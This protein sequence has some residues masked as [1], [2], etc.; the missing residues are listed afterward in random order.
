MIPIFKM[1]LACPNCPAKFKLPDGVDPIGKTF[2]CSSCEHQWIFTS[3]EDQ[4]TPKPESLQNQNND[5]LEEPTESLGS[6][7]GETIETEPELES[8]TLTAPKKEQT[9][10]TILAIFNKRSLH[11]YNVVVCVLAICFYITAYFID[12]S[13]EMSKSNANIYQLMDD[14]GLDP[15][16]GLKFTMVDC[17]ISD[18]QASKD[19]EEQI[20]VEVKVI[21]T[22]THPEPTTLHEIRFSVYNKEQKFVGDIQ[23]EVD[24]LIAPGSSETIE[25]RLN[26][27]PKDTMFVAIDFGG[28]LDLLLRNRKLIAKI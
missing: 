15:A 5:D 25:G 19:S 4:E 6:L 7:L 18:I 26:R 16:N 14:I 10:P 24:K 12:N 3:Q 13:D 17:S 20:E 27:V 1:I 11:I 28:K 9:A 22:N 8:S 2:K 23:M 21:V